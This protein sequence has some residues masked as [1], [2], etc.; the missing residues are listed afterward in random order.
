MCSTIFVN[1]NSQNN[2]ESNFN[3]KVV[4][5]KEYGEYRLK[6]NAM[7]LLIANK[8]LNVEAYNKVVLSVNNYKKCDESVLTL[9]EDIPGA[10]QYESLICERDMAYNKL[11]NKYPK[12]KKLK[13]KELKELIKLYYESNQL[14]R[15][16]TN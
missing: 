8:T 15:P 1:C 14:P 9:L 7:A 3:S 12:F 10:V 2:L 5:S 6:S 11:I 4:N 13:H 16:E